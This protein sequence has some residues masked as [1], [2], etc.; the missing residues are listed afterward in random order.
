MTIPKF[1]ESF[2]LVKG[3]LLTIL[4]GFGPRKTITQLEICPQ[5]FFSLFQQQKIKLKKKNKHTTSHI[6]IKIHVVI[7]Q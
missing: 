5:E 2:I 7:M 4:R 6:V 3:S 1:H